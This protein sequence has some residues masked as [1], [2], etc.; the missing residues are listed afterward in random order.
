M[1][2]LARVA[3]DLIEITVGAATG[4]GRAGRGSVRGRGHETLAPRRTSASSTL[5]VLPSGYVVPGSRSDGQIHLGAFCAGHRV[6][7]AYEIVASL[8]AM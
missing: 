3:F 1:L 5:P 8:A 4:R 6:A 2:R 7:F